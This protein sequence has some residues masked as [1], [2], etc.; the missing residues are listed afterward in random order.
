MTATQGIHYTNTAS[1]HDGYTGTV[2]KGIG[3]LN[4]DGYSDIVIGGLLGY[5]YVLWGGA[6]K[7]ATLDLATMNAA[8]TSN[9]F[10]MN[11][12]DQW[13]GDGM[14]S[15]DLNHDGASDLIIGSSATSMAYVVYGHTG[16]W[17]TWSNMTGNTAGMAGAS[18]ATQVSTFTGGTYLGDRIGVVGDVNGDSYVDFVMNA[19]AADGIGGVGSGVSTLV[20]GTATG[21]PTTGVINLGAGTTSTSYGIKISG[22]EAYEYLGD[23]AWDRGNNYNGDAYFSQAL[24]ISSIGDFNGDGIADMIIGSPGWG[25]AASGLAAAGRAYV[26]YGHTGA[27]SNMSASSAANAGK[28][29]ILTASNIGTNADLGFAVAGGGDYNKDGYAD[30]L[31]TAVQASTNGLTN[32]GA[33]WLV[34]GKSGGHSGTVDLTTLVTNGQ[35]LRWDGAASYNFMGTNV[36]MGDWNGDGYADVAIPQWKSTSNGAAGAGAFKIYYGNAVGAKGPTGTTPVTLDLNGDGQIGYG[37]VVMDVNGD[38]QKELTAWTDA[39]DGVLVWDKLG[40]S[41]VH[42]NSQ[43]A[44]SQYGGHTDLQGLA[45]GFDTNQDGVFDAQDARFNAF[46]VWQ[47]AN[48]NGV[49]DAGEVK[50]LADLGITSIHLTSDGVQRTPTEG[51]MEFGQTTATLA[52]GTTVRVADTA[53]DFTSLNGWVQQANGTQRVDLS[54][55]AAANTLEIRLSDVLAADQDVLVVKADTHDVVQLDTTAWVNTGTTTTVDAHT[56]AL[57]SQAGAHLLIDTQ[58]A[59]HPLIV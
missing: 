38:G 32:N 12:A 18:A 48:Q 49:S 27:W 57:W 13:F 1:G 10:M 28:G 14:A 21:Y 42:D 56:Y 44:F 8:A 4:K 2:V 52:D 24:T 41:V 31:V 53:F 54:Q 9:G 58:A 20:F 45:A 43:Y 46:A 51:V 7:A 11:S 29:F 30:F 36:A 33:V 50:A 39:T 6:N 40:D 35:A 47:D 26:F 59:V 34:F 16:A 17:S 22:S 15:A 37:H 25:D 55:D 3:D 23:I 19:P 5:N